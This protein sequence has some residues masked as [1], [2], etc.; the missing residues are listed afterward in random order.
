VVDSLPI[1]RF[2]R[3][4]SP[5]SIMR[6]PIASIPFVAGLFAAPVAA[7][8]SANDFK[9]PEGPSEPAA[10]PQGPVDDTGIIPVGPRVIRTQSEQPA[11]S[12][13][14]AE[15]QEPPPRTQP[16]ARRSP[17][18]TAIPATHPET[19]STAT[20]AEVISVPA[21][22]EEEPESAEIPPV[23]GQSD[24]PAGASIPEEAQT[25]VAE[26]ESGTLSTPLP[27]W[28]LWLAGVLGITALALGLIVFL[29]R[30]KQ[31]APLLIAGP[32][33]DKTSTLLLFNEPPR[34]TTRLEIQGF[35]RSMM[36]VTVKFSL[37]VANR[38]DIAMRD[39][40]IYADL[41]STRRQLPKEKQ[42]ATNK[43]AMEL[44][45]EIERIGP[46][47]S[48]SVTGTVQLRTHDIVLFFQGKTPVFVPLIRL[49][50][51]GKDADP[52]LQTYAVGMGS[53]MAQGKVSPIPLDTNPGSVRGVMAR[54][55][56]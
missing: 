51:E 34:F 49:H 38:S 15:E 44:V 13:P 10:R 19:A 29:R 8:N 50:V 5:G 48:R 32:A 28:V 4:S 35:T 12:T 52:L 18:P 56:N 41:V 11:A 25:T 7:Q 21:T 45:G 53:A 31:R 6:T 55:L 3:L 42:V 22:V 40:R 36:M 23:I 16:E 33:I 24:A 27:L 2:P 17:V 30:R 39:V 37:Q 47:Q 46:Q 9:L 54:A 14:A 26:D 20:E 43:S 1:Q